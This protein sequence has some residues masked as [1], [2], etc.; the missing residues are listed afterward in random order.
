MLWRVNSYILIDLV[1][2]IEVVSERVRIIIT[3]RDFVSRGLKR[4]VIFLIAIDT[5]FYHSTFSRIF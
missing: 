5:A 3:R 4:F 1:L 2:L